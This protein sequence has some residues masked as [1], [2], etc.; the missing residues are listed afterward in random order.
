[1]TDDA[2]LDV[3]VLIALA[4]PQH[5]HHSRAQAWLGSHP[6]GFLTTPITE[7]AFIRLS[8][9]RAVTGT[10][11]T[12]GEVLALV[13]AVRR[14]PQHRFLPD[15]SSLASPHV[16]TTRL[17]ASRQVTDLHL[18]NLCAVHGVVLITLDRG[19]PDMLEPADRRHVV[20]L[21]PVG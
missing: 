8:L 2:L 9:N 20:V 15:D 17:A 21:E 1:M 12:P 10:D 18:V 11:V 5:L 19:I 14:H 6:S 13:D 3:N 7:S 16:A 4:W